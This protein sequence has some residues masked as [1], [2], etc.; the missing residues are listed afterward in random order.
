[1]LILLFT[2]IPSVYTSCLCITSTKCRQFR[3]FWDEPSWGLILLRIRK[4]YSKHYHVGL[5]HTW[6]DA[7]IW[8][9]L[10]RLFVW[11]FDW[12]TDWLLQEVAAAL[13]G[14]CNIIPV[15]DNFEWPRPETLP[16][17]M[18]PICYF[19]CIRYHT[20]FTGHYADV[21]LDWSHCHCETQA[22]MVH[23]F[24]VSDIHVAYFWHP[25]S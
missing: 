25:G 5:C 18:R 22:A 23:L 11:L 2:L 4:I 16:D 15:M 7:A 21:G 9:S 24:W 17:D 12:L 13:E 6:N 19:N 10:Q 14:G 3:N 8:V 1:M 20:L